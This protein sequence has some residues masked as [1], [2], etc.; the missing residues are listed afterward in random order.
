MSDE[1]EKKPSILDDMT[2]P[3]VNDEKQLEVVSFMLKKLLEG[4]ENTPGL[5]EVTG[6]TKTLEKVMEG[7]TLAEAL[8]LSE[9]HLE[10]MYA[11]AHGYLVAGEPKKAKEAFTQLIQLNPLYERFLYGAGV[12]C[13]MLGHHAVAAKIYINFLAFDATNPEGYLRLGECFLAADELDESHGA[14]SAAKA[15]A[16]GQEIH[17]DVG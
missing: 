9:E 17:A 14:F 8:D 10:A 16:E 7:L 11:V 6:T 1:P 4:D 5:G 2:F 15:M 12:A 3:D 13:Q